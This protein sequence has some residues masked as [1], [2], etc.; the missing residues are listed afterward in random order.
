M[1]PVGKHQLLRYVLAVVVAEE[2]MA[3]RHACVSTLLP[4]LF[5]AA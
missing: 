4:G 5:I 3:I 1:R 2:P